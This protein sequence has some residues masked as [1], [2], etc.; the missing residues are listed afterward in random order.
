MKRVVGTFAATLL[1]ATAL[2]THAQSTE[3]ARARTE[4]TD[5]ELAYERTL[6]IFPACGSPRNEFVRAIE[7]QAEVLSV[8]DF[9][10]TTA[11]NSEDVPASP[12]RIERMLLHGRGESGDLQS[13]LHRITALR[14]SRVMDFEDIHLQAGSGRNVSLD[15]TL[16]L[17]CW[18]HDSKSMEPVMPRGGTPAD[19]ELA[20]IRSR[21]QQLRAAATAAKQLEERMQ[22]RRVVNALLV[23]ADVWGQA[24]VGVLDAHFT[25]PALK[26]QGIALGA[27]AKAAVESSLRKPRFQLEGLD[28]SPAGDCH[29]F[30][31]SA[32]LTATDEDPGDALPMD[33]FIARDAKPCD[34]ALP[35][36]TSVSKKGSGPLTLRLRNVD[37]STVFRALNDLSPA[38]GFVVEPG[39]TGRVNVDFE[40]VTVDDA[41]VALSAARV[42]FATPG[43]LHR[44]C[45]AACG[46]PTV[47][48]Q[49]H[50]G[51][52]LAFSIAEA[53]VIDVLRFLE[54]VAGLR[55]HASRDLNGDISI[56]VTEAPWDA[57]FDG[58]VSA[59]HRTY[60]IDKTDVYIGDRTTAV[61]LADHFASVSSTRSL[62]EHDPRKIAAAD[63]RLAGI[64]GANGTW[65]GYGRIL[66]SAKVVFVADKAASLLDASVAAIDADRV[67]LRTTS[68]RDVVVTLP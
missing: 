51:E 40:N 53:D 50:K 61:P 23:L 68:G 13:L 17:G 37:V 55:M 4:L 42:A 48:P 12:F 34:G 47:Q 3:L 9:S 32:R 14:H 10:L 43:P 28:W 67:T 57:V 27:S 6:I 38:D 18:N 65:K 20:M 54:E 59:F 44:I 21:T 62:V 16:T 35:L 64:G 2:H 52:P 36:A 63:F 58:I 26:V 1:L 31:A 5:A 30:T 39:V 66:G 33:M 22:P 46:E 56:F 41:L 45:K 7:R 8:G 11:M 49:Q 60:T 29:A 25:A 15:G 24:P 19:M